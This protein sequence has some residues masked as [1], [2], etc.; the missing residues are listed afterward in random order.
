MGKF[1]FHSLRTA[2]INF[3]LRDSTLSPT[4]MQDLARHGSL[5]MTMTVYGRARADRMTEA[6]RRISEEFC[7]PSAPP[8]RPPKTRKAQPLWIQEVALLLNWLRR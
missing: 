2:Y 3:V 7:V 8:L 6:A 5:D 4:D 1:D